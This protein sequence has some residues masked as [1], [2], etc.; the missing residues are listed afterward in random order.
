MSLTLRS[1]SALSH[2]MKN[3]CNHIHLSSCGLTCLSTCILVMQI[4]IKSIIQLSILLL[5]VSSGFLGQVLT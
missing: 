5:D 2:G 4:I 3:L 1:D